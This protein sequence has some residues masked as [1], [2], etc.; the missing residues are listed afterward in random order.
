STTVLQFELD[1]ERYFGHF[2]SLVPP[3]SIIDSGCSKHM[4]G[5]RA[6]L[7]NFMEKFLETVRFGNN[8]FAVIAGYG[9]VVIGS[10]KIKKVYYVEG[11]GHN[12]FSVGRFCDK[13]LEVAFRKSTCFVRNED[14]VD[15]LTACEQGKIHQKHHKSKTAFASNKPLYLLHIDL[16]GPMR[17]QSINVKRYVLVV[18][19]DYSRYTWVFFLYSKDEASETKDHPLQ[20][21]IGDPMSSVRTRGQ[22]ANSCMLSLIEPANMAEALR[23]VD[24]SAMQE[25]LDQFA[26]LKVWRLVPRPEGKSV[27]KTKW[28]FKNKKDES[29]L[30]IQNKARLVAV[31]YSQQEGIDYDET[32]TPVAR[33]EAIRLFLAY[34]AHKNFTI[35]QMDVKTSFLNEILNE[36]V[37]V[38]QPLVSF[39]SGHDDVDGAPRAEPHVRVEDIAMGSTGGASFVPVNNAETFAFTHD[40]D[41][42]I[43]DFFD[44]QTV[45]TA[46]AENV[47]VSKWSHVCMVFE[48]RL[49]YEHEIISRE[50]FQ[51]KFID[52]SM[53]VQQC[54]AEIAALKIKLEK[55][56]TEVVAR[57]EEVDT[58]NK[59]ND[60]LLGK[61]S[62]LE[63]RRGELNKH[64][65]R[66]GADCE[67]LWNEVA[68]EA[69]LREDFKSFQDAKAHHFEENS[70]QLDAHIANVRRYMDDD[71]YPHMFTAIA[72]HR[73]VLGHDLCLAVMKCAQFA[74]C[75]SALGRVISLAN[76]NGIQEGLEARIEHGK[77]RRSLAQVEAYD[78]EV[79]DRYVVA[80]SDFDN[81]LFTLLD[82]L[83]SLSPC[84]EQR[85]VTS[86]P[87]LQRFQ[88]LHS[89]AAE[90]RGLCL[91][92][93]STTS[94]VV[95]SA[96]L[97]DSFIGVGDISL[98]APFPSASNNMSRFRSSPSFSARF[99]SAHLSEGIPLSTEITASVPRVPFE[100]RNEPP[101]QL[102]VGYV[103]ILDIN[104]FRHFLDI[105]E[106]Y[107]PM[108][109]EPMWVADRVVALTSGLAIIIPKTANEFD[110]K[111][112]HLTLVKEN[113]FDGRI[114]TDPHKHIHEFLRICDM[115]KYTDTENEAIRLMMF[116][117]SLTGEAKTWLNELNEGTNKTW[118]E[119][120]TAFISRF[121][122]SALFDRLQGEIRAFSQLENE[123]LTKAW[124]RMKELLRNCRGHN[125]SKGNIIKIF[126][127]GLNEI[128]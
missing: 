53:V 88:P 28:I 36:E 92:F 37:Y 64:I 75:Q 54:D 116:F 86:A 109:D 30:V 16:C 20:K 95:V 69:R 102:R 124:L 120:R 115:F 67:R 22:L 12:L 126:Y 73:W 46:T 96:P 118:D 104:Y 117:L 59:Q 60:E 85:N 89:S 2:A 61:V 70:A 107:N 78:L 39:S 91:L 63:S 100:Q 111:G 123:T 68:G 25:E 74:E 44:S 110:I 94:V 11:L 57:S 6:L 112:N 15:L 13:G 56:E 8:G 55:A 103:P 33:I 40:A 3:L 82:E 4:T 45:D 10:M 119:L 99:T 19:D 127:H 29:S 26:R 35:F 27:I 5:N 98:C 18:V 49:R 122:P 31:G 38:G 47:Y 71:L 24:W 58:L 65:I 41:S 93:G 90:R 84:D 42:P 9:D 34:A 79:K 80:V 50:K 113:Q 128:T 14:G 62:A 43:D 108:D 101:A 106:N 105:L 51:K 72:G 66:L 7:T 97:Q 23:D 76:D 121:L 32:F 1:R 125:L 83:E 48:L 17:I 81:V 77:S 21:I 52:D 87:E 114:K